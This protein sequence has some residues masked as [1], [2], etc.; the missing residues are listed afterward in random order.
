MLVEKP[1]QDS[2][3]Y[4]YD[5]DNQRSPLDRIILITETNGTKY[6]MPFPSKEVWDSQALH[7]L[8]SFVDPG[9]EYT[10]S[11]KNKEN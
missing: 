2:I 3:V 9:V 5:K 1:Q 7:Y 11:F 6:E 8:L 4:G 10:V